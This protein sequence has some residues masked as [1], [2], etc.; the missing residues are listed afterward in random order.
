MQGG[1]KVSTVSVVRGSYT[2]TMTSHFC[3][4]EEPR[5]HKGNKETADGGQTDLRAGGQV[6]LGG[7]SECPTQGLINESTRALLTP[8]DENPQAPETTLAAPQMCLH[9]TYPTK[10]L[11]ARLGNSHISLDPASFSGSFFTVHLKC[12]Q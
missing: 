9:P 3:G 7:H 4:L 1:D 2:R 12:S 11:A 8:V 10:I 5:S 6:C